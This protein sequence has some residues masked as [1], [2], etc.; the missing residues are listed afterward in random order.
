MAQQYKP[1]QDD[2]FTGVV[3]VGN[4]LKRPRNSASYM[5]G[6]RLLPLGLLR[7]FGGRRVRYFEVDTDSF[8][9]R[10]HEYRDPTYAGFSSQM[11]QWNDGA[12]VSAV[13]KWQWFSLV[14]WAL[15]DV[16]TISQTLDGGY[17]RTNIAAV[18]NL[19]DRVFMYNGLGHRDGSVSKPALSAWI[20]AIG[21][22]HYAGLDA[23]CPSG[24]APTVAG[25][26]GTGW[27]ITAAVTVWIGLYNSRSGHYSNAV[28]CGSVAAGEY[29][30]IVVSSMN[31]LPPA[32]NTLVERGDLKYVFY[33]TIAGGE[34]GY[35]VMDS[36]GVSPY[37][38]AVTA[39]T[40]SAFVPTID[41]TKRRPEGNHPPRPMRW[42][43]AVQSIFYGALMYGGSNSGGWNDGFAY[44][45][46]SRQYAGVVYTNAGADEVNGEQLGNP[47]ESWDPANFRATP[48]FEV[49]LIGMP[50]P[51]GY[52]L[53]TICPTSCFLFERAA[54]GVH[55]VND[56]S[57]IHG[58]VIPATAVLA[59]R[60]LD[61]GKVKM[62]IWADQR[63]QICA[64][65]EGND[66]VHILSTA[67]QTLLSGKTPRCA[68]YT[69]DPL[70]FIDRYELYF[71]DGTALIHDFAAGGTGYTVAADITAAKT[72]TSALNASFH[73]VAKRHMYAQAGQPENGKELM[74]N[75]DYSE[76]GA[77]VE[78]AITG[79]RRGQWDD[80][81]DRSIRK[82]IAWLDVLGD[83]TNTV[84]DWYYDFKK[85]EA[86]NKRTTTATRL[87]Q[88]STPTATG[89]RGTMFMHRFKL[90]GLLYAFFY[91][92]VF[93][94][95]GRTD[96]LE[97]HP[98]MSEYGDS[99]ESTNFLGSI[100]GVDTSVSAEGEQR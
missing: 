46:D 99:D 5:H 83:S 30:G 35:L 3:T 16:L 53:F 22:T 44:A 100:V 48:N 68:T 10:F 77:T 97:Y 57:L 96:S 72:L 38:E 98:L 23:Y 49:P 73:M 19:R 91:K 58:I 51:D 93:T 56:V 13:V 15:S 28:E 59:E 36:T 84:V 64:L 11:R 79:V 27:V 86:G 31:R 94:L 67:Y 69:L 2:V 90:V 9:Q 71:T 75:E 21:E 52:R 70:N 47:E 92:F 34:V 17:T 65:V 7:L 4:V 62:I 89:P 74:A 81:G 33:C 45:A 37:T 76:L 95:T 14:S 66:S 50:S 88:T 61:N 20:P 25:S 87:D 63:N 32:Y 55:E 41:L 8:V 1:Q 80:Y 82:Q 12:G 40:S 42:I 78:T 18:A 39:T 60:E 85:I 29:A 6:F 24:T 43:C 26:A 54:D